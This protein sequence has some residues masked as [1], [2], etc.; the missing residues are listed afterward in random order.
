MSVPSWTHGKEACTVDDH[1]IG[2][3][4]RIVLLLGITFASK[5]AWSSR[6]RIEHQA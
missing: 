3:L 1:R 4:E 6:L 5:S 2:R